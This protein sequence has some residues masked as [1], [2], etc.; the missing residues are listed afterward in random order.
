MQNKQT[1][2]SPIDDSGN[3]HPAPQASGHADSQDS[4][5]APLKGDRSTALNGIVTAGKQRAVA[6]GREHKGGSAALPITPE[7]NPR[8]DVTARP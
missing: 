6:S 2:E 1:A 5:E 4:A 7:A 8:D 3:S